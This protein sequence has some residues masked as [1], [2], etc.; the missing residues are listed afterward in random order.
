MEKRFDA[1]LFDLDGTLLDTLD[2][3]AAAVNYV[4]RAYRFPELTTPQVRGFIGNGIRMLMRRALPDASA[5]LAEEA[6]VMF[7]DY[8]Q[9]HLNVK[10]KPYPGIMTLVTALAAEKI[11]MAIVSNKYQAGLDELN[12][13]YFQ[14]YI[15]VAIGEH[16]QRSAKPSPKGLI[17]AAGALGL[18][19][20]RHRIIY[21]GDSVVDIE[22]A[23]NANVPVIGVSWGFADRDVLAGADWI[24]DKP[25]E[26]LSI[27]FPVR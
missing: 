27:I 3:I 19:I 16:P 18:D 14:K 6:A 7:A 1:V 4:M 11:P 20:C 15:D 21:I 26:I 24:V 25:D 10:T 23:K 17:A 5:H 12:K 22:T 8:Y 9:T 2:D 13:Y